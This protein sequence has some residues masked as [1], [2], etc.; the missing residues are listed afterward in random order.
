M[1]TNRHRALVNH[2]VTDGLR[3]RRSSTRNDCPVG[4]WSPGQDPSTREFAYTRVL[5]VVDNSDRI[6]VG[7][8]F[9]F[10]AGPCDFVPQAIGLG[11]ILCRPGRR[12]RPT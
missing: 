9:D 4:Y 5:F 11:P 10:E 6:A 7:A 8:I 3:K 12:T 2:G 1:R